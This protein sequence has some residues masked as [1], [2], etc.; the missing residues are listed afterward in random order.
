MNKLIFILISF[1]VFV[2][3][4]NNKKK[5]SQCDSHTIHYGHIINNDEVIDEV[6]VSIMK[7]PKTFTTEDIVEGALALIVAKQIVEA[8]DDV[9]LTSGIP[10]PS[11]EYNGACITNMMRVTV[12]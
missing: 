12:I 3:C 8:G 6:L 7:A 1:V 9:V 10:A 2:G 4:T 5:I 11:F